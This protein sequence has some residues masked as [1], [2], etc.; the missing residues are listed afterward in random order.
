MGNARQ[1][2]ED[3]RIQ[4]QFSLLSVR[5]ERASI[6]QKPPNP[7]LHREGDHPARVVRRSEHDFEAEKFW[8]ARLY[9]PPTH[10]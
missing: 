9:D 1:A 4:R 7:Q 2:S 6:F 5:D 8:S 10:V 3:E